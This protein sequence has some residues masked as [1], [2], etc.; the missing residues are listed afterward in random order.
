VT[1]PRRLSIVRVA[2]L[3]VAQRRADV[4]GQLVEIAL[5]LSILAIAEPTVSQMNASFD[6]RELALQTARFPVG[7]PAVVQSAVD[8]RL[9]RLAFVD[10]RRTIPALLIPVIV[11]P[12]EYC[13]GTILAEPKPWLTTTAVVPATAPPDAMTPAVASAIKVRLIMTCL[14]GYH[15]GTRRAHCHQRPAKSRC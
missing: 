1:A 13:T 4:F 11:I 10:I 7:D 2:P 3:L 8:P 5:E 14:L 15:A 9:M 12:A 6:G